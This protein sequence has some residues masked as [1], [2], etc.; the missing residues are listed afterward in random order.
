MKENATE[1]NDQG[2]VISINT[3]RWRALRVT[4]GEKIREVLKNK[5]KI[6]RV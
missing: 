3:K 2:R 1:I 6:R 4:S 5:N